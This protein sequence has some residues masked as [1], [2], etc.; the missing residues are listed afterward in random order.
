MNNLS[1]NSISLHLYVLT[2]LKYF[3]KQKYQHCLSVLTHY[4]YFFVRV[5]PKCVKKNLIFNCM[6]IPRH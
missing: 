2:Q 4:G 5:V 6:F 1:N 3:V